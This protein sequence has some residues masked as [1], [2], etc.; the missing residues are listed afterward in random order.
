MVQFLD[1]WR[2]EWVVRCGRSFGIALRLSD[3]S[4]VLHGQIG[5]GSTRTDQVTARTVSSGSKKGGFTARVTR[6]WVW[7]ITKYYGICPWHRSTLKWVS[8]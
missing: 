3:G 6:K 1:G 5:V 2:A 8:R 7:T 4:W